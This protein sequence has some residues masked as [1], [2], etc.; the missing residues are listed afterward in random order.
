MPTPLRNGP[1]MAF[2]AVGDVSAAGMPGLEPS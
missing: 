1:G 2:A